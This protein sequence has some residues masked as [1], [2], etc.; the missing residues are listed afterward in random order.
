[1]SIQVELNSDGTTTETH[2]M[3]AGGVVRDTDFPS[4][5]VKV[6]RG[7]GAVHVS[8]PDQLEDSDLVTIDG[9]QVRASM[10]RELGILDQAFSPI[11]TPEQ[12]DASLSL[13]A[14]AQGAQKPAPALTGLEAAVDAGNMSA[15]EASVHGTAMG[16][17]TLAGLSP[18]EGIEIINRVAS[19]DDADLTVDQRQVATVV[20]K[21][22]TTATTEAAQQELGMEAFSY[23]QQAAAASPEVDQ[24]I[25]NYAI[26][27]AT[28]KT[29]GVTFSDLYAD[30][31]DHMS[32]QS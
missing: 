21:H 6:S 32:S 31:V 5:G 19:G 26:Q 7:M 25:R 15:Q 22:V 30:V 24:A 4:E 28:G 12:L 18:E 9:V 11:R 2:N 20:E 27:R 23:L 1:M 13:S 17:L 8:A 3:T 29:N 10:A 16:E 14:A